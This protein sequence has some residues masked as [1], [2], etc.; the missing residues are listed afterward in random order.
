MTW[1]RVNAAHDRACTAG[2]PRQARRTRSASRA[3]RAC[4]TTPYQARVA[5]YLEVAT[6]QFDPSD[7]TSIG[8]HFAATH[9]DP[10]FVWI[11]SAVTVESPSGRSSGWRETREWLTE[12][13]APR[14]RVPANN[15]GR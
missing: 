1:A 8:A 14:A 11:L 4:S 15:G 10:K 2:W 7:A 12:W 5:G 9:R 13:R 3:A 6:A